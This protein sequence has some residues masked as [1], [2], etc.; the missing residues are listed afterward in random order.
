MDVPRHL[1]EEFYLWL[2]AKADT[3]F[4]PV[5]KRISETMEAWAR[6]QRDAMVNQ[7]MNEIRLKE[8]EK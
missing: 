5:E 4:P 8:K 7:F 6:R 1:C 3:N 2:S